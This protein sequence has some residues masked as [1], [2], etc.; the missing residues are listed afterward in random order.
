M[1][2]SV[3]VT[4]ADLAREYGCSRATVSLALSGHPRISESVRRE[5]VALAERMNY[6]PDPSLAMLA[7]NRFARRSAEYRA[8]L[9][10][11]VH[12]KANYEL[13]V[14]H[15]EAAR[16]RAELSGYQVEPFDLAA[17]ASGSAA[18]KVL[19]HRGVRGIIIPAM[20]PL[21]EKYLRDPAWEAFSIV[22]CS[23]GWARF[24]YNVVTNDVFAGT[25][26]AW[27]RVVARGYRR[28]GAAMFRHEPLAE[29]DLARHGGSLAQQATLV[30]K[31][32]HVPVLVDCGPFDRD[33]FLR[34]FRRHRPEVV[35]SFISRAYHWLVEAGYRV[36][37][38]VAFACL[39]VVPGER[40]SGVEISPLGDAAVDFLIAQIHQNQRGVPRLQQ[41][42][43]IE[44]KWLEGETLPPRRPSRLPE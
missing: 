33:V 30:P 7:R 6:T 25:R 26:L 4:Q 23:L 44:P 32:Q 36:P 8:H 1:T 29:D 37:E 5:I 34:W 28:I 3:R 10:Y 17:Y 31:R 24:V 20:P 11:L 41:T 12:S 43:M 19:Y 18:A 27:E 39:N 38:D 16:G 13:Q 14:R 21:V 2:G 42:L 22:C 15:L 9:A 35:I 40:F